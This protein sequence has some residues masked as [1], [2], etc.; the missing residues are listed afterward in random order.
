VA[1]SGIINFV[2]TL[3][4]GPTEAAPV[5]GV[6]IWNAAQH[7][8]QATPVAAHYQTGTHDSAIA[9]AV[10]ASAVYHAPAPA[11]VGP[12][13]P[14][15]GGSQFTFNSQDGAYTNVVNAS[16]FLGRAA[17][18]EAA[19]ATVLGI[20]RPFLIAQ[21]ELPGDGS[22]TQ[23]IR[24]A[25]GA[26]AAP[27]SPPNRPAVRGSPTRLDELETR[28]SAFAI[29]TP[30][31]Q[32][33]VV[34]TATLVRDFLLSQ[35]EWP[36]L[37]G[38]AS[39]FRAPPPSVTP[40]IAPPLRPIIQTFPQEPA[41]G[42]E[43]APSSVH[44]A[45]WRR[46]VVPKP[47]ITTFPQF[48]EDLQGTVKRVLI[49]QFQAPLVGF[50]KQTWPQDDL[51]TLSGTGV[52]Y[53]PPLPS[54]IQ[55]KLV[56]FTL[57]RPQDDLE[58]LAGRAS[59]YRFPRA[60]QAGRFLTQQPQNDER[61]LAGSG[62]VARFFYV[63]PTP[64]IA[65]PLRPLI[66]TLPQE[67]P[68]GL[69]GS[70]AVYRQAPR[71]RPPFR[72]NSTRPQEDQTTWALSRWRAPP[73]PFVPSGVP[74]A[75]FV[76]TWPQQDVSSEDGVISGLLYHIPQLL[77]QLGQ[78]VVQFQVNTNLPAQGR[79]AVLEESTC[80]VTAS[81]YSRGGTLF[82]PTAV[83]YRIDDVISGYN[84]LPWTPIGPL[85][86]NTVTITSAQNILVSLSRWSETHQVLFEVTDNFGEVFYAYG[87]Y[88][89]IRVVGLD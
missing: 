71:Q 24:P 83:Q 28:P 48:A 18:I 65:P 16:A 66:Q 74:L 15:P 70:G 19:G 64:R 37:E 27:Q 52:T 67:D 30:Y 17:I 50:W 10:N 80:Y 38:R 81:Y 3:P 73:P 43:F 53:R 84:I 77:Y 76:Q 4:Q 46:P 20:A 34:P 33:Q 54:I 12:A 79:V 9:N 59:F 32:S 13:T 88:D 39:E 11:G 68:Q 75:R 31:A 51:G 72:W 86:V 69:A 85:A 56:R 1:V 25:P 60:L 58:S 49:A 45:A 8:I 42:P 6:F 63:P 35:A 82:V 62:S 7:I 89:V 61:L 21:D 87:Q 40:A 36:S 5:C 29:V 44:S 55:P 41:A 22:Y 14:T 26:A 47:P 57:T 2:G 78:V 23:I